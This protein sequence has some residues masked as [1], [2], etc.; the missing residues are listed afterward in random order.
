M[1]SKLCDNVDKM[2]LCHLFILG[3]AVP[4]QIVCKTKCN[5]FES[6]H[7]EETGCYL[8]QKAMFL[9]YIVFT[10]ISKSSEPIF[11]KFLCM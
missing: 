4:I 3:M 10:I 6:K 5:M 1:Y 8:Q 9:G 7:S 11:M 2:A